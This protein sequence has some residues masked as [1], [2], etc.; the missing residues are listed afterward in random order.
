MIR[1]M[2]CILLAAASAITAPACRDKPKIPATSKPRLVPMEEIEGLE[3][4]IM[5]QIMGNREKSC[6]REVLRG[7]GVEGTAG[8]TMITVLARLRS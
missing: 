6:L 3:K 7:T 1:H 4:R 5:D 2:M 8:P